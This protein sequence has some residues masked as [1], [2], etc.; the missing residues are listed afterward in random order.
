MPGLLDDL[1]NPA[2]MRTQSLYQG[3]VPLGLG[4]ATAGNS[5]LPL[6]NPAMRQQALMQ[7]AQGFA[8]GQHGYMQNALGSAQTQ[9]AV[10]KAKKEEEKQQAWSAGF[11][12]LL[13]DNAPDSL[14]TPGVRTAGGV[15][16]QMPDPSQPIPPGVGTPAASYQQT[17]MP[18]AD[19]MSGRLA[20]AGVA[21][22]VGNAGNRFNPNETNPFKAMP[23]QLVRA[24]SMDPDKGLPVMMS[25]LAKNA[26]KDN[27]QPET[28]MISGVPVEGQVSKS[29]PNM[30]Q[31]KPLDPTM[32]KTTIQ[33]TIQPEVAG[34]QQAARDLSDIGKTYYEDAKSARTQL[35]D[36]STMKN[37]MDQGVKTGFG[38]ETMMGISRAAKGLGIDLDPRLPA[39]EMFATLSQSMQVNAQPK[40]QGAVSNYERELF[41]KAV[42]N[43]GR[44]TEGNKLLLDYYGKIKQRDAEVARLYENELKDNGR[45]TPGFLTKVH[46]HLDKP[47][48]SDSELKN[49]ERLAGLSDAAGR[50][51]TKGGWSI[52]AIPDDPLGIRGL[53]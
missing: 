42:V 14:I 10:Q 23:P 44:S 48:F 30:G 40:G 49:M 53:P 4:L 20:A 25:F 52:K 27:W 26:D 15:L 9:L 1:Y 37:L 43:M 24:I 7:G 32:N 17:G 45:I 5:Y 33:N 18:V 46:D 36:L 11:K 41:S 50:G 13:D 29:G 34:A 12:S 47:L 35:R 21:P 6:Q 3:M 28:R 2:A 38:Q 8:Q 31:W 51:G 16:T 39:Q 22:P 19:A